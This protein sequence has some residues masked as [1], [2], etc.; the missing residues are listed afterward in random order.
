MFARITPRAAS[1]LVRRITT[2]SEALKLEALGI[3]AGKK[4][5]YNLT[6]KEIAEHED[7]KGLPRSDTGCVIVDTG[8]F[9]GRSPKD[10]WVVEEE[11][12][13]DVWWG[14]IN[15]KMSPA[16]FSELEAKCQ[17]YYNS[18]D[19][20]YVFDGYCGANEG[21]RR[22]I[23]FL[24]FQPE[25]HHFVRN[26]F[27]RPADSE[28][29][30]TGIA[31]WESDFTVLNACA[32]TNEK[33][34]EH[35]LNSEVFVAL[36]VKKKLQI[37]G[38]TFYCGE[39]KK[40]IFSMMNYWLPLEGMLP[41]HCSANKGPDGSTALFF[42]LSG[43]GK[44]TLSADAARGLIGD[45]E[46]GWDSEG[47][48]N[49]EGGCYAKTIDLLRENEPEIWD[50]I[51]T[52]ALLENVP[53]KDG[54][55]VHGIDFADTTKTPNGR[56]AYPLHHIP[57]YVESGAGQHPK[58]CIFLTCD[59]F[60]VLPPVA[61]LSTGQAMYHFISGFTAKVA[62]TE[63]GVT[64]PT[65]TFSACFGAAFLP[66]HPSVYAELLDQ[67]LSTHGT[68]PY[69][70]NTGW[71]G[72]PAQNADGTDRPR[73]SIKDTR[74]CINAILD[75]SIETAEFTTCPY[76]GFEIPK[77]LPGI[78]ASVL[79]PSQAWE[80][81]DEYDRVSKK[82]AVMFAHNFMKYDTDGSIAAHGPTC[83]PADWKDHEVDLGDEIGG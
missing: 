21:S 4:V 55:N 81:K 80:D 67:K 18:L 12:T 75:G 3:T 23:R 54:V 70:V 25:Q 6:Y 9:T 46:H 16:T 71:A 35:G 11:E 39:M 44:T 10:K 68:V 32:I 57:N 47:I 22:K 15:K 42:G 65:P 52:D 51:K 59:A 19:E 40:G 43:T 66:L 48:F 41:M 82:L 8:K 77:V 17:D 29:S 2:S 78:D 34:K 36:S 62:G 58:A 13:K 45:D 26:M 79:N 56:V 83:L 27:I 69:L 7:A 37:I 31:G 76:F 53:Q 33:W 49:F 63:R 74:G 24:G 20:F 72:G 61:R 38:G 5:H 50:A 60:G 30:A 64:E 28:L 73:M 14:A 1:L